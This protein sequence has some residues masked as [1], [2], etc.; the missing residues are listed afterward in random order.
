MIKTVKHSGMDFI[1]DNV[2]HI[3]TSPV[4]TQL[5]ECV[6]SVEF[7][8]SKEDKLLFVE[9]KSS[10][11]NPNNP[12]PNPD[13]GNKTGSEL[14]REEI[15]DICDKFIHSL[16][17]YSAIDVG[18]IKSKFPPEYIPSGNVSLVFVL[19]IKGFKE[20]WCDAVE[21][22]LMNK[23]CESVC[24]LRIWKPRVSVLTHE[25]AIKWK[26]ALA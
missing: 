14:F 3:E 10:F 2:F 21:R 20:S 12:L 16:N 17:L 24:I 15:V 9:A 22:A 11:P 18:V 25:M 5:G 4:Y 26:I 23:I 13:K 7:I 19:V 6:K 1:D 8:R